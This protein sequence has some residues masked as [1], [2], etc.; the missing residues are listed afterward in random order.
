MSRGITS[1]TS[2]GSSSC[3]SDSED[4]EEEIEVPR[5]ENARLKVRLKKKEKALESLRKKLKYLRSQKDELPKLQVKD[6][7]EKHRT[8]KICPTNILWKRAWQL[9][10]CIHNT[11]V[12]V[13]RPFLY[14]KD[15]L[16][17][18][19]IKEELEKLRVNE[20]KE[21]LR[22]KDELEK[23]RVKE[24]L[25]RLRVKEKLEKLRVKEELENLR[26]DSELVKLRVKE[27]LEKLRVKE[28][29]EKFRVKEDLEKLRVKEQLEKLRVGQICFPNELY[30]F[31]KRVLRYWFSIP[32]SCVYLATP[33]LDAVRLNDIYK[34]ILSNEGKGNLGAFF[35]R[36]TCGVKELFASINRQALAMLSRDE[37]K[38]LEES[39]I[40]NRII[41]DA[42][43]F[44]CK[45]I[46][47][48]IGDNAEVLISSANF[49]SCHF[50]GNYNKDEVIYTTM[51]KNQFYENYLNPLNNR[52]PQR[53]NRIKQ[54]SHKTNMENYQ[55]LNA[56][57]SFL[58]KIF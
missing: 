42:Q 22:L 16:E 41:T 18:L 27:E 56:V 32:D 12:Y 2:T 44:H 36:Q 20:E 1:N 54:T 30:T 48:V 21:K 53:F 3:E 40:E 43:T 17:T 26:V 33:F 49:T 51:R 6:E 29:Q 24:E 5:K 38:N 46:A 8:E 58:N 45:F 15:E 52:L 4:A 7:L 19:R 57:D 23:I 37:R 11:C 35:V 55:L 9:W 50:G 39:D 10:W 34:I 31:W 14:S 13:A 25:E 28:E 47:C